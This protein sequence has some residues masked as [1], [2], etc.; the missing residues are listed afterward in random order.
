MVKILTKDFIREPVLEMS[1]DE[2]TEE[3]TLFGSTYRMYAVDRMKHI[4]LKCTNQCDANCA[5]CIERRSRGTREDWAMF[6]DS[7]VNTIRQ[8]QE[9]RQFRSLSVT[10]GEPTLCTHIQDL[11]YLA[12][13]VHPS[14]FSINTDGFKLN[15]ADPGTFHGWLNISKH[16]I[17]DT[18]IFNRPFNLKPNAI[19]DFKKEQPFAKVRLQCVLGVDGGLK[20]LNDVLNFMSYFGD[21]ADGFSFRSLALVSDQDKI[22]PLFT[23]LRNFLFDHMVEQFIRNYHVYETF[24]Y[25]GKSVML[26]WSNMYLAGL[27]CTYSP[28]GVLEDIVVHPDGVVTGSWNREYSLPI[29]APSTSGRSATL[30]ASAAASSILSA[31]PASESFRPPPLFASNA[32]PFPTFVNMDDMV[33]SGLAASASESYRPSPIY[34]S[35]MGDFVRYDASMLDSYNTYRTFTLSDL[36]RV[37]LVP[38]VDPQVDIDLLRENCG[39]ACSPCSPCSDYNSCSACSA[40]SANSAN[41]SDIGCSGSSG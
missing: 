18:C 22:P 9:Q 29:W 2:P 5:F 14:L 1:A 41:L 19:A 38:R 15:F 26:S 7:A 33:R 3:V 12:S 40:N 20:T 6:M 28:P 27:Q 36:D 35:E 8:M 11:V 4:H 16:A 39:M 23:D 21:V 34:L 30:A 24:N 13:S 31:S 25:R 37:G 17:N 32:S 10:G